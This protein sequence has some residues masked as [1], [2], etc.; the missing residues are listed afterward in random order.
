MQVSK[1]LTPHRQ[2][3]I[4]ILRG[5]V[6]VL[7][8]LDH[9]RDFLGASSMNPR[10]VTAP[11]LFLTRWIT[12]FCA[13]VF[14]YLTGVSAWFYLQKQDSLPATRRYLLLRGLWLI[15]LEL[16]LVRLGWTFEWPFHLLILQ[17]IWVLGWGMI[18]LSL[19]IGAS[20]YLIGAFGLAMMAGHHLLDVITAKQ[21][22]SA[23]ILWHLLH[24]PTRYVLSQHVEVFIVYP[25]IPWIGVMAFGFAM[26]PNFV[27]GARRPRFFVMWGLALLL[28]FFLLR[29]TGF[30]GDPQRWVPE[31]NGLSSMLS[32]IN[33]EKYPPSFQ[34]L[35]MTLGPVFL[36]Y[37]L[38]PTL[39][40]KL[41]AVL[42]TFGRVPLFLYVFHLPLLHCL[43]LLQLIL[44]GSNLSELPNGF[45]LQGKPDHYGFSLFGVY[46][47]WMI[48]LV[49]FYPLCRLYGE[50]KFAEKKIWCRLL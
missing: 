5:L 36:F 32:F 25:L 39:P 33:C 16:T 14:V 10:D 4:D 50:Q 30:Y 3:A 24:E 1:L 46:L 17:V 40:G 31:M 42:Q 28:L 7:M 8:V 11:A 18:F 9:T 49:A 38:I 35:L 2:T 27:A 26:A 45:P 20:N 6:I 34:F 29:L 37:P 21:L 19:L 43:A 13:P 23:A 44:T 48:V 47:A 22:G 12:H 41:A 15:V